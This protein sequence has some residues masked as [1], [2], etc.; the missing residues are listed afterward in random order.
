[1]FLRERIDIQFFSY[2]FTDDG[3]FFLKKNSFGVQDLPATENKK[4]TR[5]ITKITMR[6]R[7]KQNKKKSR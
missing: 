3:A 6:I 7:I 5:L 2:S 1:M 4:I